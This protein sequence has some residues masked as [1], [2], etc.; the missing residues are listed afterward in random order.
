MFS[1]FKELIRNVQSGPTFRLCVAAAE[2]RELLEAVKIAADLGFAHPVLVGDARRVPELANAAGLKDYELVP[3]DGPEQSAA[4]AVSMVRQGQAEVLMKGAI[5]TSQYLRAILNREAGLRSGD[6]LSALAVYEVKEYH[7]L[8]FCSDSGINAAPDLEQKKAILT[9][10]LNAM[11]RLGFERPLVA[12]L[13]ASEVVHPK[14]PA[15]VDAAELARL[16][17][18]G[19]FGEC[20][21]EGPIAFD[22]AFDRRAAE[23]KGL[24][25][26]LSGNVDL[27]LA[28]NIETGNALGKSWLTLSKAKWAGVV[29]GTTHPVVLGSRSDTPDV[30]INS[31]AL[32]C[33]LAGSQR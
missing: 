24:D 16:A 30:K 32:A 11:R 3:S 4:Q 7:K 13:T 19:A 28:P 31:I 17:Q 26:Q 5:N 33:L 6:L 25:S 29:L 21:V 22:V 12:A 14:V 8:I 10:A 15:T 18:E 2:D 20:V 27:L 1:D 23:H 9:N